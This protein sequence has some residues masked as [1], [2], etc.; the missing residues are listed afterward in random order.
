MMRKGFLWHLAMSVPLFPF[1]ASSERNAAEADRHDM[2]NKS[3]TM[4]F[5]AT[6]NLELRSCLMVT[7]GYYS[8][9]PLTPSQSRSGRAE[10]NA[11]PKSQI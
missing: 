8:I 7:R 11:N 9:H 4:S 2:K 1:I 10:T 5:H 3:R 6:Q